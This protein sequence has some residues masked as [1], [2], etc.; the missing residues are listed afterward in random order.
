MERDLDK[1]IDAIIEEALIQ[2]NQKYNYAEEVANLDDGY[3][4]DLCQGQAA[5]FVR[6]GN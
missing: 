3:C 5:Y 1:M 4:C 2:K 6:K